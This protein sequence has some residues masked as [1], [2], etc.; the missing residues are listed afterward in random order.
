M[1]ANIFLPESGMAIES[2]QIIN[3]HQPKFIIYLTPTNPKLSLL[4]LS[5]TYGTE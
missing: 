1:A 4:P 5:V 3:L 2:S